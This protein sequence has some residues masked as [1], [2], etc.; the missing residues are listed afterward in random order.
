M[1][2]WKQL[3]SAMGVEWRDRGPN[4][5]RDDVNICCPFCGDDYGFHLGV[6]ITGGNKY[7]C[8]RN[9]EHGGRSPARLLQALGASYEESKQLVEEYGDGEAPIQVSS[10]PPA[11]I[12]K[13]WRKFMSAADCPECMHYLRQRGFNEPQT[14]AKRY[15]LRYAP[16]GRWAR[17]VIL[18]VKLDTSVVSWTARSI[19]AHRIPK[20]MMQSVIYPGLVYTP[21]LS[22]DTMVIVE[23]PLDA[24]KIAATNMEH[25]GALALMGKALNSRKLIILTQLL[26]ETRKIVFAPDAD[27]DA[28]SSSRMLS[29]LK[30]TSMGRPIHSIR[31]PANYKDAGEMPLDV[32][33]PWVNAA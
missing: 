27:V 30:L 9:T 13:S 22:R 28:V 10:T 1:I 7:Y 3:F 5:T 2:D 17:R 15:D 25:V 31:P 4:T 26:R 20:Y 14:L 23:G 8:F 12:A 29:L 33:R 16:Y 24:L 6:S 32:I 19:D 11:S 18:P 21:K